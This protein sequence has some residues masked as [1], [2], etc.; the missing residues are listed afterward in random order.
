MHIVLGE[1][2]PQYRHTR[3]VFSLAE[4]KQTILED[5]DTEVDNVVLL[6]SENKGDVTDEEES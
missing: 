3:R 6:P 1:S 5:S 4:A 2:M